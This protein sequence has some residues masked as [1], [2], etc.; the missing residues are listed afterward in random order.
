MPCNHIALL[1]EGLDGLVELLKSN[2]HTDRIL[3]KLMQQ[4]RRK[5]LQEHRLILNRPPRDDRRQLLLTLTNP[6][7]QLQ[8][9]QTRKHLPNLRHQNNHPIRQ[10]LILLSIQ[11]VSF[12]ELTGGCL[13][14]IVEFVA[15]GFYGDEEVDTLGVELLVEVLGEGFED[16]EDVHAYFVLDLGEFVLDSEVFLVYDLGVF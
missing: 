2:S 12:S 1:F 6:Q 15:S 13:E 10:L 9:I 8:P 4:I 7:Q 5:A 14:Q 11:L 3:H 16:V